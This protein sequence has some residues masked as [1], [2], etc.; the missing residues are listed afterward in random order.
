MDP[1]T[2]SSS[3][4]AETLDSDFTFM[5][6]ASQVIL[7][8]SNFNK[9]SVIGYLGTDCQVMLH[10]TTL[11]TIYEQCMSNEKSTIPNQISTVYLGIADSGATYHFFPGKELL[12]LLH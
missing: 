4:P 1:T 7:T 6:A 8:P 10:F 9:Q 12:H 5:F 11:P 3:I 2:V